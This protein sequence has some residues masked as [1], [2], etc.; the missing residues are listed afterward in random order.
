MFNTVDRKNTQSIKWDQT[1]KEDCIP[2][3]IADSDYASP[4][5]VIDALNQRVNH[6]VFGYT[7]FDEDYYNIIISFVKRHYDYEI[8]INQITTT[9][10]VVGSL[11][12]AIKMLND[13]SE[14]III[15]TPVYNMFYDLIEKANKKVI[16]NKL[17][18]ENG[19]YR[20]DF[21]NLEYL[22]TQG[23]K[24]MILCNPHNP[25]G[26]VYKDDEL[27]K[28]VLLAKKYDVHI[29]SDEIH[30]DIILNDNKFISLMKYYDL[31]ENMMV[32]IAPSKT[33]NIAGLHISLVITKNYDLMESYKKITDE[34][35]FKN[36]SL[37]SITA[38]KAAYK[39]CDDW[40][41][42]Q[43]QHLSRNYQIIKDYFH[44]NHPKVVLSQVEGTYL[45]WLDMNYLKIS[46]EEATKEL[47]KHH[48]SVGKGT[49]YSPHSEGYFRLNFACS[50]DQ[51]KE[52]LKRLSETIK[53]LE[54][55]TSK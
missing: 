41:A 55:N 37:L 33:F 46:C 29:L 28:L 12:Y 15:Q 21:D 1:K 10:G 45:V 32:F 5:P 11:Y 18:E 14:G 27:K 40:M 36:P 7:Y 4:K 16:E 42:L 35:Y 34:G 20:M 47:M 30:A 25:V 3:T 54:A 23:H 22:F 13:K 2:F 39:D 9:M 51:L 48:I 44:K 31:Y 53:I 50:T 8:T 43:N 19:Y 24:I 17:I 49:I 52:G 6:G 26:R 38:L